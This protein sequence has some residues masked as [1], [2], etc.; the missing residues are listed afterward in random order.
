MDDVAPVVRFVGSGLAAGAVGGFA[1][2]ALAWQPGPSFRAAWLWIGTANG[3][4]LKDKCVMSLG[5][6]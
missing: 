5:V 4:V 2:T 3:D 1:L 6:M